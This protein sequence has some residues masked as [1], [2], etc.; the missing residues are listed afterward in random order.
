MG[1][2]SARGWVGFASALLL[3][4]AAGALDITGLSITTTGG[5]TAN[6]LTNTGNN[7]SQVASSTSITI[8][9]SGPVADTIGSSLSVETRY[10]WL[11]A[12]DRNSAGTA[13]TT[14]ATAEYQITFTVDNPSGATY[15]IDIDTL[16]IGSLTNVTDDAGD[17]TA[18]LGAMTGSVDGII[19]GTLALVAFGPFTSGATGTSDFSQVGSTLSITDNALSRSFTLAFTWTGSASSNHDES[20]IRMGVG[21]SIT[22]ASADDYP[23]QGGRTAAD[24]GHFVTVGATIISTPEPRAGMLLMLGLLGLAVKA[25]R[26]RA[27]AATR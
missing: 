22:G 25:A 19:N 21:G 24:D 4:P 14:A 3:A 5:N 23:G 7:L 2:I 13:L 15:R 26:G 20:A 1:R 18:T 10:A 8:P 6:A 9:S 27:V 16:R 11:T 17:G 12:A